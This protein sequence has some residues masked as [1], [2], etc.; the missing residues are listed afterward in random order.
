[1][2]VLPKIVYI[3][4]GPSGSG[5]STVA[6]ILAGDVGTIHSTDHYFMV[7]D[8]YQFDPGLLGEYHERNLDAF[9]QSLQEGV[10]IVICDNTNSR[11]WHREPYA[12]VAKEA[13]YLVAYVA[14]PHVSS[15]TLAAR[16]THGVPA[17]TIH[18]MMETWEWKH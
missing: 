4:E 8:E 16:S 10:P 7:D 11:Q 2:S 12:R 6:E 5:K 13:G 18:R 3:M 9:S 1:M 14:M 15:E 17:E